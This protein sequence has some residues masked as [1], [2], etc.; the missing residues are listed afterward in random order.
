MLK[1]KTT[2]KEELRQNK[3][4]TSA[5]TFRLRSHVMRFVMPSTMRPV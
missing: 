3:T 1:A 2:V 5:E 4:A